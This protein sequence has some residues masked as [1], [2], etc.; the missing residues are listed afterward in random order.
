M[1]SAHRLADTDQE[2]SRWI[3]GELVPLLRHRKIVSGDIRDVSDRSGETG[4]D[5]TFVI[6]CVAAGVIVRRCR[7]HA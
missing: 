2:Q 3:E 5:R 7:R 1:R 6:A 4:V